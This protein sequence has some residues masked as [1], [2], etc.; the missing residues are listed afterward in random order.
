MRC[1]RFR[2]AAALLTFIVGIAATYL[3]LSGRHL[4]LDEKSPITSAGGNLPLNADAGGQEPANL[5]VPKEQYPGVFER[6][7]TI[8][9]EVEIINSAPPS[10]Q[11]SLNGRPILKGESLPPSILEHVKR[12][13][14][15]YDDVIVFHRLEGSY[16][17]GGTF[18]FLGIR[19]DGSYYLSEGIGE[20]FADFPIV[21]LGTDYVKVRVRGGYG[22]NPAPGEPYLPGGTWL[23]KG[24]HVKKI[25]SGKP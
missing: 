12:G 11:I 23:F 16:C 3:W 18:W 8:A 15:P 21:L 24:G 22:I 2:V 13:I 19:R 9:G 7:D 4:A 10:W 6:V 20:C 25:G 14:S 5:N 1:L 17:G